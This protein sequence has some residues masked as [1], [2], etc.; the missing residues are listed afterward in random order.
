M[1]LGVAIVPKSEGA[2]TIMGAIVLTRGLVVAESVFLAVVSIEGRF[3]ASVASVSLTVV[4]ARVAGMLV[5]IAVI[6][7]VLVVIA[8][9]NI[10]VGVVVLLVVLVVLNNVGVDDV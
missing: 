5:F 4:E 6:M 2:V 1:V 8:V 3:W 9:V 10:V 7:V